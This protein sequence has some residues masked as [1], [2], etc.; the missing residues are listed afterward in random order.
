MAY[1]HSL[2][3]FILKHLAI[4]TLIQISVFQAPVLVRRSKKGHKLDFAN[5]CTIDM[6]LLGFF[7]KEKETVLCLT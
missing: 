2:R 7:F 6:N 4:H 5:A 1:L 3:G